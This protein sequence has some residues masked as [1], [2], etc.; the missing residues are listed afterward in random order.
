MVPYLQSSIQK[1]NVAALSVAAA[2][3][4]VLY[5]A[6]LNDAAIQSTMSNT[7]RSRRG[8]S[9]IDNVPRYA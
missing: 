7:K 2:V 6:H 5:S 9:A 3:I 1:V 4:E 8:V